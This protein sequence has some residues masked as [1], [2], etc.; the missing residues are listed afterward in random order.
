MVELTPEFLNV[1][2]F[3]KPAITTSDEVLVFGIVTIP[4]DATCMTVNLKAPIFVDNM[5]GEAAQVVQTDNDLPIRCACYGALVA[6][7]GEGL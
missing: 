3:K 5:N 1:L 7:N 6:V 4:D 2:G